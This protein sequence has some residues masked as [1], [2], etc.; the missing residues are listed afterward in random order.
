M[1]PA[2]KH[3]RIAIKSFKKRKISI[4]VA[5]CIRVNGEESFGGVAVKHRRRQQ[6]VSSSSMSIKLT[7][8]RMMMRRE[9]NTLIET[10]D[11]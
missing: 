7:R 11:A 5:N 8:M 3:A 6:A 9:N 2:S 4:G 10:L 1:I